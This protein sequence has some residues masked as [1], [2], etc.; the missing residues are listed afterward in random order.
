MADLGGGL[1]GPIWV[2]IV[3]VRFGGRPGLGK[4]GFGRDT[5]FFRI[6]SRREWDA[7]VHWRGGRSRSA[8][9]H[10]CASIVTRSFPQASYHTEKN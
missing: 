9:M 3:L 2:V 5:Q 4:S 1:D 7:G 6:P 10:F 8:L